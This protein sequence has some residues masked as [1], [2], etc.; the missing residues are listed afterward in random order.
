MA[1]TKAKTAVAASAVVLLAAGTTVV[2][3]KACLRA[4][5]VPRTT[6]ATSH[7]EGQLIGR[8]ELVDAGN[9]TPEAAWE[10]RYWARAMG[11]YDAVIAAT[12]PKAVPVAKAWMG[13]KATFH[14]RSRA[15]FASFGGIRISARKDLA[16]DKVEL[17]YWF[18]F[19]NQP[20]TKIVMMV[21]VNGAWICRET[22]AYDASWD[23][24]SEPEAA[25]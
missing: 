7:I 6:P 1:W 9:T 23:P 4:A 21:R 3:L 24:G 8:T 13:E 12:D 25:P 14:R 20:Q 16:P 10:S 5:P 2:T 11:D 18:A 15:E 17:K 19:D 22:R